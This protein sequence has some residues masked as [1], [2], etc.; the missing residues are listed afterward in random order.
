[1]PAIDSG[2]AVHSRCDGSQH[3][4]GESRPS[5]WGN[6]A[7]RLVRFPLGGV[8]MLLT[9]GFELQGAVASAGGAG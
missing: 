7:P 5:V 1:M 8:S 9:D 2:C 6:V 3:Q 4:R